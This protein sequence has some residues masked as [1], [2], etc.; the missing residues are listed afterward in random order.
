MQHKLTLTIDEDIY[1]G[2]HTTIGKGRISQF[3]EN[4]IRPH[5]LPTELDTAYREMSQDKMREHEAEAWAE[6]LLGD[7]DDTAR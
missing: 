3:I 7:I 5:V 6:A 1:Q 2:L 4:L